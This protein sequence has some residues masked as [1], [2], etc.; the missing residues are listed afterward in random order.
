MEQTSY[1]LS[2]INTLISLFLKHTTAKMY[3][4]N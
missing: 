4:E 3:Y 2:Y 1:S